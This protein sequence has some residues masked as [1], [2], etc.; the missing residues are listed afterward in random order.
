MTS[1]IQ[2]NPFFSATLAD[3]EFFS[4]IV[5]VVKDFVDIIG[6]ATSYRRLFFVAESLVL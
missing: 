6:K 1:A 5:N 4:A 2:K 3:A